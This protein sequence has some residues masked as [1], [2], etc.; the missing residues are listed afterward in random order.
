[1]SVIAKR[2]FVNNFVPVSI[3]V[4]VPVKKILFDVG[5]FVKWTKTGDKLFVVIS[6]QYPNMH[7]I[8]SLP[9]G[10]GLFNTYNADGENLTLIQTGVILISDPPHPS[11]HIVMEVDNDLL[12][13]TFK[14]VMPNM[15]DQDL[16]SIMKRKK[17]KKD[18]AN[19][20]IRDYNSS[21]DDA[22]KHVTERKW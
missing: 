14:K 18:A 17:I 11:E 22:S 20:L 15:P 12:I 8:R 6:S 19:I 5:S 7:L 1:M 9:S 13:S 21:V 3:P 4:S 2:L 10:D 16:Y